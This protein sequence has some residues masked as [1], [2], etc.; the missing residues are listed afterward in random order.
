MITEGRPEPIP[1]ALP[2][3]RFSPSWSSRA[4]SSGLH[5]DKVVIV[6]RSRLSTERLK[7]RLCFLK[8]ERLEAFGEPAVDRREKIAGFAAATLVS[9]QPGE[10]RCGAQFPEL[11]SLLRG[12]VE[13]FA[14]QFLG[15]LGISL[16]Q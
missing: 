14:V 7:Q 15:G 2:P 5:A 4:L 13:G 6:K 3:S 16:P 8:V 11:G 1:L 9:A 10:A 12:D